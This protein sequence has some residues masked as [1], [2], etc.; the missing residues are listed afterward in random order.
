MASVGGKTWAKLGAETQA[1]H[2]QSLAKTALMVGP[3]ARGLL[4]LKVTDADISD[5]QPPVLFFNGTE[6]APF[7]AI[8]AK[9]IRAL[10][11]DVGAITVEGAGH[12]VHRDRPDIVN[13][14]T[15]SF[16]GSAT[17]IRSSCPPD[18]VQNS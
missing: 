18:G 6:S 7:E 5:L 3:H 9:R 11:P 10:R 13:P 12:N 1:K 4:D 16:L 14:A 2:V 8:I 15:L 17:R